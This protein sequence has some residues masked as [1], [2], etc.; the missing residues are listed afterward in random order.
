MGDE[1]EN[2]L[3]RRFLHKFQQ[4]VRSRRV[5]FFRKIAK[6]GFVTVF[7]GGEGHFRNYGFGFTKGYFAFLTLNSKSLLKIFLIEIG[8]AEHKS[9][10]P[11]QERIRCRLV[12][13]HFSALVHRKHEMHVRMNQLAHL[14]ARR[15]LPAG[16]ST[17]TVVA[18]EILQECERKGNGTA[19][20]VLIEK[21]SM[22]HP[23]AVDHRHEC[24]F[25]RIISCYLIKFHIYSSFASFKLIANIKLVSFIE[26]SNPTHFFLSTLPLS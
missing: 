21:H 19:T 22:R 7:N 6:H 16:F 2:C 23:P 26:L 25:Q 12:I 10:P 20:V 17:G 8:I 4:F 13:T 3:L 1:Y 5:H 24:A 14:T 11:C 18:I 9:T 15:A